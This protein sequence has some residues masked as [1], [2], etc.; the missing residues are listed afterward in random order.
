VGGRIDWSDVFGEKEKGDLLSRNANAVLPNRGGVAPN[1]IQSYMNY[2]PGEKKVHLVWGRILWGRSLLDITEDPF[3]GGEGKEGGAPTRKGLK[4]SQE[5]R[6][7]E[8]FFSL[9]SAIYEGKEDLEEGGISFSTSS[10]SPRGRGPF[11]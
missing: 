2:N 6:K 7:K 11:R 4:S 8:S 10:F 5:K 3:S 1:V 9:K